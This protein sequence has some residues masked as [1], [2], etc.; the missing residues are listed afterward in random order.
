MADVVE[1]VFSKH[2]A[3]ANER[4]DLGNLRSNA[5]QVDILEWFDGL[6]SLGFLLSQ[7][8][9][10]QLPTPPDKTIKRELIG[11]RQFSNLP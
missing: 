3:I 1:R 5:E 8:I 7:S 2:S 4:K 11:N 10:R 6:S 9:E